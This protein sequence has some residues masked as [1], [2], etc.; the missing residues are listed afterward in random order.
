MCVCMRVCVC[1]CA[2]V[3]ACKHVCVR[4]C[5]CVFQLISKTDAQVTAKHVTPVKHYVD[6]LTFDFTASGGGS[7]CEVSVS[8]YK[9][10]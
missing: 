10:N 7:G 6:D 8:T 9:L 4:A 3:C 2:C 1:V 5:V